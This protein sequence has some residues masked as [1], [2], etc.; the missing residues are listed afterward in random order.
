MQLLIGQRAN[1]AGFAFPDDGGFIFA[2][3][4]HVAVEAVVREVDLAAD[5]PLGPRAIP[6]EN[7]VPFLEP[8]QLIGDTA[9]ELVGIVNRFLVKALVFSEAFNVR[10][11]AEL[12]GRWE[13]AL[14]LKNGIDATGLKIV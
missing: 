14:L 1:L 7:F 11:L 10:M 8:V 6:F 5:K 12:G 4:L 9:P 3:G 13:R 2:R